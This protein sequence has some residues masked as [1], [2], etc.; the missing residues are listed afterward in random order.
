MAAND[1][2]WLWPAC[3]YLIG[4]IPTGYLLGRSRGIDVRQHG[5]GNIGATNVWRV[6]GR[7]W[8][9]LAFACDFLK[10]FL[11]L[12]LLWRFEFDGNTTWSAELLLVLC[13]LAAILGHNFTPWLGFRGGKG[14]ATSA[15][16]MAALL[17][18]ALLVAF[19]SWALLV[20]ITRTVSIGSLLAAVV[21]PLATAFFYPRQWIYLGLSLMIGALVIWRHRAN[22][23]RLLAGTEP[24][25]GPPATPSKPAP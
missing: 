23:Q 17:P 21:L 18:W 19:S 15:G 13:G 24:R 1:L 10:G 16:V 6:M 9:L 14:V 2:P 4:S 12:F 8:G 5:S 22:I 25:L 20:W 3:F 7:S 11:P